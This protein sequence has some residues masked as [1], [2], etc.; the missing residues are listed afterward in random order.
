MGYYLWE[1]SGEFKILGCLH[2]PILD[3]LFTWRPI[4]RRIDFYIIK[5]ESLS[6]FFLSLVMIIVYYLYSYFTES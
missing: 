1:F 6:F 2:G 5:N 4:E 3:H